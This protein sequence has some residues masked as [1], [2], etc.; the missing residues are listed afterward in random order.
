MPVSSISFSQNSLNFAPHPTR[1]NKTLSSTVLLES[2]S[3]VGWKHSTGLQI[4]DVER[5]NFVSGRK[6]QF[7][8]AHRH[9]HTVRYWQTQ[10]SHSSIGRR[11]HFWQTFNALE[12]CIAIQ[13]YVAGQN[14]F[15]HKFRLPS[16][17]IFS[18]EKQMY[19][20]EEDGKKGL[21]WQRAGNTEA[22]DK[23]RCV[24]PRKNNTPA[25]NDSNR[26]DDKSITQMITSCRSIQA[27]H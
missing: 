14:P 16:R 23:V 2:I 15:I 18:K 3:R 8:H 13:S 5:H 17:E 12:P 24:L 11:E 27:G 20:T 22:G 7:H 9:L 26:Q 21:T 25:G 6:Q 10:I 4:N 1:I 19:K